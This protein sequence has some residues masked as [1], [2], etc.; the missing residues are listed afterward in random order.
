MCKGVLGGL[1]SST[2]LVWACVGA[3]F[4]ASC[5]SGVNEDQ[6]G[7]DLEP[8]M[9]AEVSNGE[10]SARIDSQGNISRVEWKHTD[11]TGL[12][13]SVGSINGGL[14]LATTESG[15]RSYSASR[16]LGL[17]GAPAIVEHASDTLGLFFLRQEAAQTQADNWPAHLGAPVNEDGSVRVYGDQMVWALFGDK[18]S[19][20]DP[21]GIR[22][23]ASMFLADK[24]G[25]EDVLFPRGALCPKR[26]QSCTEH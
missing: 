24:P 3:V 17:L 14:L 9:Q 18:P 25:L 23:G 19:T 4:L 7:L 15:A 22:V 1:V 16:A 20:Q 8:L 2:L 5:D 13:A 11:N 26:S 6:V 12:E 10:L 21:V